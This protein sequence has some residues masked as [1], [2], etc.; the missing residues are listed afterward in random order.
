MATSFPHF[1][2]RLRARGIDTEY[3]PLAFDHRVLDRI[4]AQTRDVDISFVGG[5]HPPEVHRGGTALLER[6]AEEL[7]MQSWGYI[8][9]SP[10][11]DSPILSRH[12]GP[13]WGLDMY[14]TLAR[15]RITVNRH[16][17]IAETFANNMRLFEATGVGALL[18]TESADNLAELFEPGREVVAYDGP[19]DLI[20]KARHYVEHDDHRRRIAAAGQAATLERHTYERRVAQLAAMLAARVR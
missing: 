17:D 10:R 13:V 19:D 4:P 12:H 15:S 20:E 14:R 5:I 8:R 6:L 16:G 3:L 7:D 2:E 18:L 9:D 1:V 11:P